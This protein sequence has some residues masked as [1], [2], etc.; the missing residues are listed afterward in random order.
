MMKMTR[1]ELLD[2]ILRTARKIRG[3]LDGTFLFPRS[4][5][6]TETQRHFLEWNAERLG[7]PVDQSYERYRHSREE[8]RCGHGGTDFRAYNDQAYRIFGVFF[9][10]SPAEAFDAYQGHALMHF[11]R[12]LSYADVTGQAGDLVVTELVGQSSVG[13]LDFGCGLAQRSRALARTLSDR[14]VQVELVL[15]DIP[16]LRKDFLLWL[17]KKTGIATRFLDC[18]QAQPIPQLPACAVCFAVDFFEH[19]H[20]PLPYLQ[21]IHDALIPGGCLVTDLAD[22]ASEF[23]H[24]A[25]ILAPLREELGRLGYVVVDPYR[26]FRKPV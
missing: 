20:V 3:R 1:T 17:G 9:D 25:P 7:I 5:V 24:V 26:V 22:H 13:I 14:G 16:T 11:L 4:D 19:V 8:F 15:A 21:R 23:M 12:M 2:Q 6:L 10:D 18:T